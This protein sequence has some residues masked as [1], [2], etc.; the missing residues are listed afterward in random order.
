MQ[1]KW[2]L[3]DVQP[4]GAA[5]KVAR[6]D[7]HN[8]L[9][10]DSP[11]MPANLTV[12]RQAAPARTQVPYLTLSDGNRI[13]M[14]GLGTWQAD[15]DQLRVAVAEAIRCGCRH[16][17][18]ASNYKN[19]RLVG[20]AIAECIREGIVRR[21]ELF[22]TTKLWNNSHS[23]QSVRRAL[24]RSLEQLQL[25]YIDLYL[26]HYPI[27]YQEGGELSPLD[28]SGQVITT[29]VDYIE[30]WAGMED[31]RRLGLAKSIGVSNFNAQQVSRLVA[32]CSYLPTMNQVECHPYLNQKKLADFCRSLGV[33]L[34]AYS[35]LGSPGRLGPDETKLVDD[36]LIT[37]L[38]RERH[39]SP[40]QLLIRYQIDR[41]IVVIPKALQKAHIMDNMGA[42]GV[43]KL[44]AK[45]LEQLDSLNK[46][47]R[48]MRFE[49]CLGHK[50]YPFD[51]AF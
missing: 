10:K 21:D 13:P 45:E 1:R 9:A 14:L 40:A 5:N 24:E 46:D 20:Q 11:V 49:R 44:E 41:G 29:D 32:N 19:E 35:P 38:A 2:A 16:L 48:Y 47:F 51:A 3:T 39:C 22:V 8:W 23:R 26:V 15:G 4:I 31:V 43:P 12:A 36:P 33:M 37:K 42:L 7:A 50:Y 28:A 34:T 17:D 27:G 6:L 30:T 25:S 18:T